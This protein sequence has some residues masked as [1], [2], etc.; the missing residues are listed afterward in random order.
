[1]GDGMQ[2]G[3]DESSSESSVGKLSYLLYKGT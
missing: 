2:D 1:M 3:V